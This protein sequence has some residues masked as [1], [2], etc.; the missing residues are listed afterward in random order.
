M[1]SPVFDAPGQATVDP[2]G[3][4]RRSEMYSFLPSFPPAC[5][6][7][8][9]AAHRPLDIKTQPR[10]TGARK[11]H[12]TKSARVN[13]GARGSV[14]GHDFFVTVMQA[15]PGAAPRPGRGF[16]LPTQTPIGI[17]LY[18][19]TRA[20]GEPC[21]DQADEL[22]E[23]VRTLA[24]RVSPME[25]PLRLQMEPEVTF[26]GRVEAFASD[27]AIVSLFNQSTGERLEAECEIET[28][29][30][31]GIGEGD[32]FCCDVLKSDS[33]AVVRFSLLPPKRMTAEQ[34][35]E[36]LKEVEDLVL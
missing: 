27:Q 14:M 10:A 31:N 24:A 28:L 23:Y 1:N 22:Q 5:L 18:P 29:R 13:R 25:A 2:Y 16:A 9:L 20:E 12:L 34:V 26:I 36:I 32:E 19:R 35:D 17:D 4:S 33:G 11:H 15:G 3:A 30:R 21:S 7:E 8:N 6:P